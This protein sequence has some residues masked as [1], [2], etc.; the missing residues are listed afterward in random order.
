MVCWVFSVFFLFI[1]N[2]IN[3]SKKTSTR[4][5]IFSME[6]E[7]SAPSCPQLVC[8]TRLRF[9]K[10]VSRVSVNSGSNLAALCTKKLSII[11]LSAPFAL[12]RELALANKAAP[13]MAQFSPHSHQP[14][15]LAA[16]AGQAVYLFN[17]N[18][19]RTP[20]QA[21][22]A[23]QRNVRW[24]AWSLFDSNVI[25]TCAADNSIH[26]WDIRD[27]KVFTL[28]LFGIVFVYL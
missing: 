2:I 18:D 3:S 9:Q 20:L 4:G 5:H 1:K 26:L 6:A 17:L 10:D 12:A 14:S 7:E 16:Y 13:Q 27:L 8:S 21:T 24:L 15:Q 22:L 23:H 11:G 28:Y 25:A 19:A